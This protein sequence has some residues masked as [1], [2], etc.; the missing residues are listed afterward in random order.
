MSDVK[1][2]QLPAST[3][4]LAGTEL[5]PIVQSGV[6][7]QA[8]VNEFG[9]GVGYLP[10]GTGAVATTVQTKL[11]ESVSVFD[12]MTAAQIADAQSNTA[13]IDV[14]AAF[15]AA[16]TAS[17]SVYVPPNASY[18]LLNFK[19]P[20]GCCL[21]SN[22]FP[23]LYNAASQKPILISSSGTAVVDAS[24]FGIALSGLCINGSG[25]VIGVFGNSLNLHNCTIVDCTYGVGNLSVTTDVGVISNNE[26][27]N[28]GVGITNVIDCVINANY[29]HSC[30]GQGIYLGTGANDNMIFGNKIEFN[31]S[32]GLE[33]YQAT[34]NTIYGNVFDR[35]A[36]AGIRVVSS[37][38]STVTG[39]C[40]R[41]N[42]SNTAL[43]AA[44][45]A[46]IIVDSSTSISVSGNTL[47]HGTND[48]GSGADTP[49]YALSTNGT[50]VDCVYAGNV[51][52]G[53]TT[54]YLYGTPSDFLYK[55]NQYFEVVESLGVQTA[56]IAGLGN[57]TVTFANMAGTL[58]YARNG[59]IA[60]IVFRDAGT[61]GTYAAT[62]VIAVTREGGSASML[63][64]ALTGAI[65]SGTTAPTLSWSC[66][67][68]A[69][70]ISCQITNG[71]ANTIQV[72]LRIR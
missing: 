17:K 35:N 65:T 7:K 43:A 25:V 72:T 55:G 45:Q 67:A 41:R 50:N 9:A 53:Y 27:L 12:F 19:P 57:A 2:S 42:A 56:S 66:T 21:Y 13:S 62:Q 31:G 38:Q 1:I 8:T 32:H 28:C 39:N 4:P 5:V 30:S 70:S 44:L 23:G 71:S 6:T 54:S 11:R 59:F 20:T 40:F 58:A 16:C 33:S 34:T 64:G 18:K 3:T 24:N 60:D 63:A 26:I 48:D 22:S 69:T 37:N 29:V 46:N 14:T 15:L 36:G 68:G 61:G 47:F 51:G 49:A 10:A 52:L